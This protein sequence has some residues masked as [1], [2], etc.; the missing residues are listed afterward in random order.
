MSAIRPARDLFRG[1]DHVLFTSATIGN[2]PLFLRGLGI[3]ESEASVHCGLCE[4]PPRIGRSSIGRGSFAKAR[5]AT[6][7]D[8]ILQAIRKVLLRTW[9]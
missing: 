2:I 9:G 4:F 1:F 5:A 8:S 6:G 7:F 3:A